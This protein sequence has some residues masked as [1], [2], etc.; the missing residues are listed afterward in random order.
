MNNKS[1][2]K[3]GYCKK[4]ETIEEIKRNIIDMDKKMDRYLDN[5]EGKK[6]DL[7]LFNGVLFATFKNGKDYE[8][9]YRK[10]PN[11]YFEMLFKVYIPFIL[12]NL[13]C[14]CFYNENARKKIKILKTLRVEKAPEPN[15]V[16]WE[17]LQFSY[18]SRLMRIY[19]VY[20]LSF[21]LIGICFL[22]VIYLTSLQNNYKSAK[23]ARYI[24][25]NYGISILISSSISVINY[26]ISKCL[27]KIS[28]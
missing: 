18:L 27:R 28:E 23:S 12:T 17:N 8:T 2:Y 20:M 15:D 11:S 4:E 1:S 16:I 6:S 3:S 21:L 26:A 25:F 22:I 9:F 14:R 7:D 13:L 5:I 24:S 19:L 10:F